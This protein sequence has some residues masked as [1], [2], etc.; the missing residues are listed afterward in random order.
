V[1][2]RGEQLMVGDA[3]ERCRRRLFPSSADEPPG[4]KE[5]K[6]SEERTSLYKTARRTQLWIRLKKSVLPIF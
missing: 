5:I 4:N 6:R 1:A 3:A 2:R